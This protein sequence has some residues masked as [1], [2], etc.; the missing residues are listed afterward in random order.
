MKKIFFIASIAFAC[1]TALAQDAIIETF[2]SNSLEWTECAFESKRGTAIIDQGVMTVTSKGELKLLGGLAT[3]MSGVATKVGEN[4]FF[5]TH[6]YAPLD[7]EKPFKIT[8]RVTIDKLAQDRIAGLVFNYKDGGTFYTFVFNNESVEFVRYVDNQV[9]GSITQGV[10]WEKNKKLEQEWEL[11]SEDQVLTFIVDGMPI[12]KVRH[13]PLEYSGFG[14][15]TF[16][17]QKLIVDE[18]SFI[19]L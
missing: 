6:C 9:V 12:L 11:T 17:K 5:E 15:Y 7:I 14:F 13:M 1:N 10:K 2:D 18:V 8:T 3:A 19:Q 4:T 16:G